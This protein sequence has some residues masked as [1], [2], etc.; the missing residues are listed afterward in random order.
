MDLPEGTIDLHVHVAPDGAA[1]RC[2]ALDLARGA[3]QRPRLAGA[4]LKGHFAP[5]GAL[6]VL[7]RSE[8]PQFFAFGSVVLNRAV[9][10]L[11]PAAVEALARV[12]AGRDGSSGCPRAM[13]AT[14]S[15]GRAGSGAPVAVVESGLPV[16]ALHDVVEATRSGGMILASG[17]IAPAETVAVFRAFAGADL[18]LLATHVTAPVTPFGDDDLRAVLDAEPSRS[19]A[20]G[21]Y[22]RGAGISPDPT[23]ERWRRRPTLS[24]ALVPR[25]S[26]C[27]A[28]SAPP[29]IPIRPK[30]SRP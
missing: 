30:A 24:G 7:V 17:H 26:S 25:T 13:P 19:S 8:V 11:N 23:R 12:G 15:R 14:T 5:T 18:T 27:R 9:G 22:S 6:A 3:D 4:V 29:T 28:I 16:P 2:S 10:G 21:T 20:R 1:R